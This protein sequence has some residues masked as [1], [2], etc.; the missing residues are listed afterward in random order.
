MGYKRRH[1]GSADV[2]IDEAT[3]ALLMQ[4]GNT[5]VPVDLADA[6]VAAIIAGLIVGIGGSTPKTLADLDGRLNTTNSR[7]NTMDARLAVVEYEHTADSRTPGSTGMA[8]NAG[9]PQR[10]SIGS[11]PYIRARI[12]AVQPNMSVPAGSSSSS[13]SSS[14]APTNYPST[15]TGNVYLYADDNRE[16]FAWILA[17]GDSLE[18]PP[19]CDL[20]DFLLDVENDG[21][22]VVVMYSY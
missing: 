21:D 7:L 4:V 17:P 13:S 19:N 18:L 6:D 20:N 14:S 16:E 2:M 5:Q 22:G 11:A 9:Q 10:L 12:L 8:A 1:I 3:G 15:N